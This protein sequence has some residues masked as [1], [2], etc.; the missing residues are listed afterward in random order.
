MRHRDRVEAQ[1]AL[2]EASQQVLIELRT[3][4]QQLLQSAARHEAAVEG[5]ERE[6]LRR[7][8]AEQHGE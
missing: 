2:I 7:R 3:A 5:L 6:T 8:D 4:T 1:E